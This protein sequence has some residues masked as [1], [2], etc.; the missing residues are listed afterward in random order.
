MF[1]LGGPKVPARHVKCWLYRYGAHQRLIDVVDFYY[2]FAA[3]KGIRPEILV[4]QAAKETGFGHYTGVVPPEY[5]NFAGI[6]VRN[7]GDSWKAESH[8]RFY[9]PEDGVR[10]HVNHM[11]AYIRGKESVPIGVPHPRYVVVKYLEW[12]GTIRTTQQ[13]G[14]RWSEAN[15]L[16]YGDS[17]NRF[18][19]QMED[20]VPGATRCPFARWNPTGATPGGIITPR[21]QIMHC[22]AISVDAHPHSGLEWHF[23]IDFE[24]KIDQLVDCNRR[25]DANYLANNF[26]ISVENWG[27]GEGFLTAAQ[28]DANVRLARWLNV[29]WGIPLTKATRW[30]GSGQGYHTQFPEWFPN[31]KSCPGPNRKQ[32]FSDVYLPTLASGGQIVLPT[33]TEGEAVAS[34]FKMYL[35]YLGITEDEIMNSEQLRLDVSYHCWQITSG[36]KTEESKRADIEAWARAQNLYPTVPAQGWWK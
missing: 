2:W 12:A 27:L 10:G 4:A 6:K 8:E 34:V 14:Q 20:T 22:T 21:V 13:M 15:S 17:L 18:V 25:A 9:L 32:Q 26:A 11:D 19:A 16:A 24:G 30:D 33:I 35:L 1:L 31:P 23:E 28:L 7:G 3:Q 29:E 36:Q 5:N